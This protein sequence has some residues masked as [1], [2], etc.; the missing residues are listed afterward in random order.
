M[1]KRGK[2]AQLTIF[3]IIAILI[4]AVVL[5]IFL[6]WPKL[7]STFVEPENPYAY[8]E[9]CIEDHLEEVISIV[10]SQ[11]GIYEV[12]EGA[13]FFYRGDYIRFLCHTSSY[14]ELCYRQVAFLKDSIENEIEENIKNEV[15]QCFDRMKEYYER[16]G[17]AVSVEE[18][19][20]FEFKILPN[21][22][23]I[24]LGRNLVL[25]KGEDV[26]DYRNFALERPSKFYEI[27]EVSN[28]ILLWE[29]EVGESVPE[30]YM[31]NYPYIDIERRLKDNEDYDDVKIYTLT[32][33][34]TQEQ[35]KFASRSLA[36]PPAFGIPI[37]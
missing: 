36:Y 28:N 13:Y 34:E 16:E 24:N 6:F 14:Y 8:M 23:S 37:E 33:T 25:T 29:E 10:M 3:I 1:I 12:S 26:K 5:F 11:G 19:G 21:E 18:N 32:H 22:M 31:Y 20:E 15:E 2:K 27:I 7:K 35:F 4:V 17:Y 9:T 30:A